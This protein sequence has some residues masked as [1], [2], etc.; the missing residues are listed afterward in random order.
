M[1][2]NKSILV[3][4]LLAL[5]ICGPGFAI[6]FDNITVGAPQ[7]CYSESG[8]G[9]PPTNLI[10]GNENYLNNWLTIGGGSGG[11]VTLRLPS[12]SHLTS[13]EIIGH[14]SAITRSGTFYFSNTTSGNYTI[15]ATIPPRSWT[16]INFPS[17]NDTRWLS[18]QDTSGQWFSY[19]ELRCY[20]YNS[21]YS[22]FGQ[23]NFTGY[24]LDGY[25]PLDVSFTIQNYTS[26][27]GGTTTWNFGDGSI[28]NK[29]TST[30][31][32]TY[33]NAGI[34]TVS[35]SYTTLQGNATTI[36]KTNYV[37][38]SIPSGMIVNLDVKDAISG[39]LIQDSTVSIRNI[40]TGV[41]RNTTAPTG[42]VYFSTT[43][44]GYLY[45]LSQ[46]QSITLAANKTGYSPASETFNIPY[47][48]YRARLFLMPLTN[49]N[50]TG[51]GTVVANV[52]RNKDGLTISGVSVV[53]DTGQMGITNSAGAT[54]LY[55]V[56]AGTR[57]AT[58]TDPDG[59]YISTKYAF[60]LTAGETKLIV[61]Q[62][63]RVG[64]TPV[65]TPV[66]PTP[67]TSGT[68]DPNDPNS[69][70]YG[71]YTTSQINQ[72]GGAG[73]L[74]ML[75]QLIQLWPLILVGVLM[76]FLKSTFS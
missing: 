1:K 27:S 52:V 24:P 42:L 63:V 15:L 69:P 45:P 58:V 62:M 54:T 22:D 51:A 71:N 5:L 50:A 47:N 28:Q 53:M 38:A 12:V 14:D 40:T 19:T 26:I 56:T 55:N 6:S 11:F 48:N 39:A 72:E 34:Y 4:V 31:N 65:T 66:S 74:G 73:I 9:C 33:S 44:P 68:Y 76:K 16:T 7:S 61:I 59:G 57:Y 37:L 32:H 10:D 41:W 35:M 8:T 20:G 13:C 70:V 60:N 23:A 21:T 36:T 67:T 2:P 3:I 29:T 30:V 43:D 17:G 49:V 75:M 25:N 64:E 18:Y 46:N